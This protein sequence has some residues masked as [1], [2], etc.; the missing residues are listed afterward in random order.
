[1]IREYNAALIFMLGECS[2]SIRSTCKRYM[3][4]MQWKSSLF[5]KFM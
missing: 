4:E 1:V 2:L 5:Q 3:L